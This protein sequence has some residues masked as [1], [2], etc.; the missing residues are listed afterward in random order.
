MVTIYGALKTANFYDRLKSEQN[1]DIKKF[2]SQD[3]LASADH[4]MRQ[5]PLF[6]PEDL[7]SLLSEFKV[8]KML[9][10]TS[11]QI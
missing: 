9:T 7:Q 2:A 11:H 3:R 4:H 8:V 5:S 1:F 6:S 10:N